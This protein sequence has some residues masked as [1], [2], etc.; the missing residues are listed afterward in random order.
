MVGFDIGGTKCAVCIGKEVDGKLQILEKKS[1]PT[2]QKISPYEMLE[3]LCILAESMT[4]D[5]EIIGISCGG[6]LNSEQ[7]VILSPPNLS[8]WDNVKIVEYLEN[9]YHGK[10]YLQNDAD[11][12]ALAEWKF[13]AG[14][15]TKNMIF[16]TF[17]TGLGAGLILN[18]MLYTGCC[19]MAGE[20]GHMRL[21]EYG[22]IGYGKAGSFEGFCSGSGIA[23]LGMSV[24]RELL[25]QGKKASFCES[26]GELELITAK[27]VA[28]C[29]KAGAEDAKEVY[30]ISGRMLGKGLAILIDIL[31]PE[32]IVLG[33]IFARSSELLIEE[34]YRVLRNE[35]LSYSLEHCE[36]VPA[37]LGE[38]LGDVAALSVAI[39]GLSEIGKGL[40]NL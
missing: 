29:A 26:L 13:G 34:M 11:A 4:D 32:R 31:N 9:K 25:Q 37:K 12:C 19:D 3:Q 24:A 6:P 39:N 35:C 23:Q 7:G 20:I 21:S 15:G 28:E 27:K 30:R 33:S 10:V 8:G 5:M 17:G 16:C 1:V 2:N 14:K 40:K 22:P 18:G 36:I 38:S